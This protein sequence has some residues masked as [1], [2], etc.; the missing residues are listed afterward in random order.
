I[1]LNPSCAAAHQWFSNFLSVSSRFGES[2]EEIALARRLDPLNLVIRNDEGLAQ[3]YAGNEERGMA[4][5][6]ETI[7]LDR[8]FPLSRLYLSLAAARRGQMGVATAEA[9]TA[10]KLL[11]GDP[12]PI[13]LYGYVSARAGRPQEARDALRQ[14]EELSRARFVSSL[15][16]ALL[17]IGLGEKEA[18]LSALEE[19]YEQRE[20]RLVYLN[21]DRIFD[22]LRSEP[23]F[24]TLIARLKIPA[25]PQ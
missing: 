10:M 17:H 7:A 24:R 16:K 9:K 8:N 19:A 14:L 5:L 22:P 3:I 15:P 6:R 11:E 23:R 1:S 4:L 21:V 12:D 25:R 18:A 20:G 2:F 13:A